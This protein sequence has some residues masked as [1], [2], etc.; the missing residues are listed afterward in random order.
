MRATYKWLAFESA[1]VFKVSA[2]YKLAIG[3]HIVCPTLKWIWKTCYQSKHKVFFWLLVM[4]RLKTR[5]L[6]ERKDFFMADY[7]VLCAVLSY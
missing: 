1:T 2:A 3:D 6:F 4:D 5:Q 7:F